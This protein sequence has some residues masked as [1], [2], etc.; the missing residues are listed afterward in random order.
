MRR[1]LDM[2]AARQ[3]VGRIAVDAGMHAAAGL[4][5]L[6]PRMRQRMATTELIEDLE[7]A[8]HGGKRLRLDILLPEG[9]GAASDADV[10]AR[11]RVCWAGLLQRRRPLGCS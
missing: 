1:W 3:S 2:I 10:P 11:R 5:D 9:A 7:C 8:H 6:L 4:V